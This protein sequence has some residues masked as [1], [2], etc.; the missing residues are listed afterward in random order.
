MKT[1]AILAVLLIVCSATSIKEQR[2][3]AMKKITYTSLFTEIQSQITSGGPLTAILDTIKHFFDQVKAEEDQHFAMWTI[4]KANCDEELAFRDK[5]I[6]LAADTFTKAQ[7]H[8]DQ[9]KTSLE[10]AS[11]D[12]AQN[13]KGQVDT[14]S[15]L[16]EITAIRKS[17]HSVF[18]KERARHNKAIEVLTGALDYLDE[19]VAGETKV[20]L[21]QMHTMNL[22]KTGT[23]IGLMKHYAP[24]IVTL[25]QMAASEENV[26]VQESSVEKVKTLM[27]KVIGNV[28]VNLDTLTDTEAKQQQEFDGIASSLN[29]TLRKLK[30]LARKMRHHVDDMSKCVLEE[31]QVM[32]AAKTKQ[33]RNQDM[34]DTAKK[35]CD[36]FQREW[37]TAT[38]QRNEEMDLLNIIKTMAEKRMVAYRDANTE[39]KYHDEYNKEYDNMQYKDGVKTHHSDTWE[40]K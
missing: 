11:V 7:A 37:D 14:Q 28:R 9:C 12:L 38:E 35:M 27:N 29:E 15:A 6:K 32:G 36:T 1:V 8:H 25:A 16:D 5:E 4:Q 21:L 33:R 39:S 31:E 19:L 40:S 20:A 34:F 24:V 10:R 13:E 17:Q 2:L 26:F 3:K 18:V 30:D 23:K 22:I